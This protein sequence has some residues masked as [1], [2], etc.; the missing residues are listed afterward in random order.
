[1]KGEKKMKFLIGLLLFILFYQFSKR[2]YKKFSNSPLNYKVNLL[3]KRWYKENLNDI[4]RKDIS[5][6]EIDSVLFKL[7]TS[8]EKNGIRKGNIEEVIE[9]LN[10]QNKSLEVIKIVS[11]VGSII[12]FIFTN[13]EKIANFISKDDVI[14]VVRYFVIKL[15]DNLIVIISILV[16][17]LL[18]FAFK[19][20][21]QYE[22]RFLRSTKAFFMTRLIT[23][24]DY[25]VD[26]SNI[27]PDDIDNIDENVIYANIKISNQR[28][29]KLFQES[30]NNEKL[31][32]NLDF[33]KEII[34]K[35]YIYI[36]KLL[37]VLI[38]YLVP[39]CLLGLITVF[40]M[41]LRE[42]LWIN[43]IL[44]LIVS[45]VI[46]V[47]YNSAFYEYT[48][49]SK[50]EISIINYIIILHKSG[51]NFFT[52]IKKIFF[53]IINIA[54]SFIFFY[55]NTNYVSVNR[56]LVLVEAIVIFIIF[57]ISFLIEIKI[58]EE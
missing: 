36:E 14:S 54:V 31:Q 52:N 24:W 57:Q 15:W 21:M 2:R 38:V 47:F 53:N 45:L 10:K 46:F 20:A 56:V 58:R 7:K 37:K 25:R 49:D 32:N 11:I 55:V 8:L 9:Q 51:K 4:N 26:Q 5:M 48:S 18:F 13:S 6:Y 35:L 19:S 1:M 3:Y 12:A 23:I 27:E 43:V 22:V 16:I 34:R 39:I 41:V 40:N 29:D 28:I 42:Y 44:F 30:I 33:L 17:L 50:I